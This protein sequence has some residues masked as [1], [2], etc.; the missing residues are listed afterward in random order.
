MFNCTHIY[1]KPL[2]ELLPD[3][4]VRA[5][6]RNKVIV[7]DN[8]VIYGVQGMSYTLIPNEL[9]KTCVDEVIGEH[10]VSIFYNP[11]GEFSI[12]VHLP[13]D[14]FRVG[15][16]RDTI[17]KSVIIN[18]SY[19]ARVP[20]SVQGKVVNVT[21][22]RVREKGIRVSYYRQICS[23]GLMGWSDEFM[24]YEAY[25]NWLLQ[26]QP[27][28]YEKVEE[29][30]T[31][32]D[33]GIEEVDRKEE[34]IFLKNFKHKYLDLAKF[35]TNLKSI[36]RDFVA[37]QESLSLRVYQK[38]QMATIHEAKAERLIID[39]GLPKKLA[40]LALDRL[41]TERQMLESDVNLWLLYNSANYALFSESSGLALDKRYERD[42][43]I[44]NNLNLQLV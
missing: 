25:A 27:N 40:T 38:M 30:K 15:D 16:C 1:A 36:L 41:D 35:A 12:N 42:R 44:F 9:I 28:N 2:T 24:S 8:K 20:F 17:Q 11:K 26:G 14:T 10:Q 39:A 34:L 19:N 29:I 6:D 23:N 32:V 37:R 7:D 33:E 31:Y 21:E 22:D 43:D 13:N 5:T 4:T 18:N 3:Y